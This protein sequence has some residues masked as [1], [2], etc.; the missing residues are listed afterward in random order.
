MGI[1]LSKANAKFKARIQENATDYRPVDS[2]QTKKPKPDTRREGQ[3]RP[4]EGGPGRRGFRIQLV[5]LRRRLLDSHDNLPMCLKP[6]VDRITF[7]LGFDNDADPLLQWSYSQARTMGH[8][9][10]VILIEPFEL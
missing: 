4:M 3:D 2:V 10:V 8:E 1:D 7:R 9:G 5:C 6:I